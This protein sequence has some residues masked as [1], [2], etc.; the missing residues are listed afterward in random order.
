VIN[1]ACLHEA[2]GNLL[3]LF[4]LGFKRVHQFQPNEIGHFD[5]NGHGATVGGARVAHARF[6]AGPTVKAVD[7]DDAGG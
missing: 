4:V 2:L 1:E 7:V 6:V 3:G 5:F